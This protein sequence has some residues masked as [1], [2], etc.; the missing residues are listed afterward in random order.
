MRLVAIAVI[1]AA[2]ACASSPADFGP[3]AIAARRA[4]FAAAGAYPAHLWRDTPPYPRSSGGPVLAYVEIPAGSRNK[5]EYRIGDD[6]RVL[7]RVI[8]PEVGGY[9]VNYGMIP[10]TMAFDGDPLDVLVLG[11]SLK[12]GSLLEGVVVGLMDMDDEK[13]RDPKVIVSPLGPDGGPRFALTAAVRDEVGNWFN[14]Y[15]RFETGAGKWSRVTGWRSVEDAHRLIV[16]CRTF[17]EAG[18]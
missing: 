2:M 18:Q 7:D 14:G 11:P 9:P 13:G 3:R 12:G 4:A 1:G 8:R 15:K 6:A 17:F 10:G 16:R 5:H